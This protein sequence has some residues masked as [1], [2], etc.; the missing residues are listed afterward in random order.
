MRTCWVVSGRGS[1]DDIYAVRPM[2]NGDDHRDIYWRKS[3][4]AQPL[5]LRERVREAH[6]DV[7]LVVDVIQPL[8]ASD[9]FPMLFEKHIREV[10]SRAVAHIKRGDA[11]VLRTTTGQRVRAD[12]NV[13][14]DPIL[15]FLALLTAVPEGTLVAT[16]RIERAANDT[17][18][19]PR[20]ARSE[21]LSEPRAA[22]RAS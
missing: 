2:R 5:V 4:G 7:E 13:G 10:A 3:A 12:K 20:S 22:E 16:D 21:A 6:P 15:R 14:A 8:S 1:G 19:P 9:D 18:A 11:V 17:A